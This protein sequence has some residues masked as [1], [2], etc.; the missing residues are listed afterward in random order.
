VDLTR[1]DEREAYYDNLMDGD[2]VY[3]CPV[4]SATP[5]L[6]ATCQEVEYSPQ[7][8]IVE[9]ESIICRGAGWDTP[10]LP[11]GQVGGTMLS[12]T[13]YVGPMSVSFHGILMAEVPCVHTNM[14]TGYFATTYTGRWTHTFIFGDR[15]SMAWR[16]G[17]NNYW[18]VD[19]AG[20]PGPYENWSEG[21]LVWDIPIG[22]FRKRFDD[23]DHKFIEQE[24]SANGRELL[25]GG[26]IDAYQQIFSISADG[27][28]SV[29]KHR[30]KMSRSRFCHV[31]LDGNT[32]Q[33]I[34]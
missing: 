27:T 20:H 16:V 6:K 18:T 9:P 5:Q 22:W 1:I 11:P 8:T 17:T 31:R 7:M 12:L 13:N 23:D 4:Y 19:R 3:V 25:V 14:P 32:I 29:E 30:H 24:E 21:R 10:C 34:H 33:R 15:Y 26:R 2:A 28:A